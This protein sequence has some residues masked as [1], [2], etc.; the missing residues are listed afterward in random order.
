MREWF[1]FYTLFIKNPQSPN[2]QTN[3]KPTKTHM[4][5]QPPPPGHYQWEGI[6]FF[7]NFFIYS[8]KSAQFQLSFID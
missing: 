6:T 4:P 3:P 1:N 7:T 5:Q 8:L 2:P